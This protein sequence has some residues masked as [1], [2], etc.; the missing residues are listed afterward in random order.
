M[1]ITCK[2]TDCPMNNE[3]HTSHPDGIP[4]ICGLCGQEMTPNE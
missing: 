1:T 3:V 4:V 2:T